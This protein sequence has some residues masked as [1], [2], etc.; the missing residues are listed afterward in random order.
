MKKYIKIFLIFSSFLNTNSPQIA[1]DQQ[2]Q[3]LIQQQQMN[4]IQPSLIIQQSQQYNQSHQNPNQH[5]QKQ[6]QPSTATRS[7]PPVFEMGPLNL[8][9]QPMRRY[10][11]SSTDLQDHQ[12]S[13]QKFLQQFSKTVAPPCS[14]S[15]SSPR[16]PLGPISSVIFGNNVNARGVIHE[17]TDIKEDDLPEDIQNLQD[18]IRDLRI[19]RDTMYNKPMEQGGPNAAGSFI[20]IAPIVPPPRGIDANRSNIVNNNNNSINNHHQQD[21]IIRLQNGKPS[22]QILQPSSN[23]GVMAQQQQQ[24]HQQHQHN[25]GSSSLSA[26]PGNMVFTEN[27]RPSIYASVDKKSP[28][29]TQPE[30]IDLDQRPP[31]RSSAN[32][33]NAQRSTD[34]QKK[35]SGGGLQWMSLNDDNSSC[36]PVVSPRTRTTKQKDV[37]NDRQQN[38]KQHYLQSLTNPIYST[39]SISSSADGG[40]KQHQ[41]H[42]QQQYHQQQQQQQQ[43]LINPL[44]N[45]GVVSSRGVSQP[46]QHSQQQQHHIQQRNNHPQQQ[47][48]ATNSIKSKPSSSV[49]PVPLASKFNNPTSHKSPL[50]GKLVFIHL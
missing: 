46:P 33:N 28:L 41:P 43:N 12:D 14:S 17:I 15:S 32:M 49:I 3:I 25:Q 29:D 37:P 5:P 22:T 38:Q 8:I 18:D 21:S 40:A 16:I 11:A 44:Y 4:T 45:R 50:D 19:L 34:A 24:Q 2:K 30:V 36:S 31:V 20:G 13:P 35:T 10:M 26:T 23:R 27:L 1:T 47:Q 42:Q 48:Q 6:A 9:E 7:G 39:A